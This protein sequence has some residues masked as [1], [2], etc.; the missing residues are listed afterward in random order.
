MDLTT[1]DVIQKKNILIDIANKQSYDYTDQDF[2]TGIIG[3]SGT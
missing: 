3:P 1:H 2:D